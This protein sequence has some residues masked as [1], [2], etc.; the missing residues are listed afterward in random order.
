MDRLPNLT[1]QRERNLMKPDT[2]SLRKAGS[3]AT[4]V[5]AD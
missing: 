5:A 1:A 4:T 2:A 3:C